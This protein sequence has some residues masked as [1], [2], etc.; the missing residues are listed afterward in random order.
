MAKAFKDAKKADPTVDSSGKMCLHLQRVIRGMKNNDPSV[1]SQQCIPF[2]VLQAMVMR[3]TSQPIEVALHQLLILGF[4]FAMRSCE[5][6]DVDNSYFKKQKDDTDRNY[7]SKKGKERRTAPL[8]PRNFIFKKNH[9]VLRHDDPNIIYADTVTI[10]FEFQKK[11]DR[12]DPVT[13]SRTGHPLFC[14]VVAAAHIVMR[15]ME[16]VKK[17][18]LKEKDY[19]NTPIFAYT[20][21]KGKRGVVKAWIARKMLRDFIG[22]GEYA[23]LGLDPDRLGLHSI[24]ASAAM[25]MYLNKVPVYTIMLLGRWSSDAFLRYIR[26]QVEE[27]GQN[28]A[29]LMIENPRYHQII[30][31][32]RDDPGTHNPNSF[33]ANMGMGRNGREINRNSFAVWGA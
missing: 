19:W 23:D 6:L 2:E 16:M 30:P 26:K 14:P 15:M 25:A 32:S 28:V 5:Y 18:E 17:G 13:Q 11:E 4:F 12:D 27:F 1:K 7:N 22:Q 33:T 29:S 31:R 10:I 24:R 3:P 8:C 9:R 21:S 20:T